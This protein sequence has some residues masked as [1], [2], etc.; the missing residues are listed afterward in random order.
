[1]LERL[2]R[3]D[4]IEV[5][6][7]SFSERPTR[8]R[9]NDSADIQGMF[10]F[11]TLKNC[12][13]LAVHRQ[14]VHV[15]IARLAHYDLARH[16]EN[17]FAG[18]REIFASFNCRQRRTQSTGAYD[19]NQH[20][21]SPRQAGDLTLSF[22]SRKN[23]RLVFKLACQDVDLGFIDQ[24]NRLG[25]RFIRSCREFFS[26]TIGGQSDNFHPVRN[27][28]CHF[29]C[30]LADRSGRAKNDNPLTLPGSFRHHF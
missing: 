1:M 12:V 20:H 10:A 22:F 27:I 30:A 25:A 16:H 9:E 5:F 15:T 8:G 21:L 13:V 19:C 2:S 23:S 6:S 14:N 3:R 11:Q 29:Q 7:R 26:I 28:P 18:H 4:G 24:A 17:F